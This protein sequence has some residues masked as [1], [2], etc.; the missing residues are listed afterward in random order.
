[1]R[2]LEYCLTQARTCEYR[3]LRAK[4]RELCDTFSDLAC[5]WRQLANQIETL[6]REPVPANCASYLISSDLGRDQHKHL[7]PAKL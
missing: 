7:S 6:Q 3:A 4:C 2:E 5:H 1:M